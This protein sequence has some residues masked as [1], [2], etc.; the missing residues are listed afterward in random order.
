MKSSAKEKRNKTRNMYVRTIP[1]LTF[2][3]LGQIL[4]TIRLDLF[5]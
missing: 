3:Q 5:S 4:V 1:D 2:F